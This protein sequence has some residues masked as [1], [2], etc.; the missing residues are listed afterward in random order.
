[1]RSLAQLTG[2]DLADV[3]TAVSANGERAFG[4]WQ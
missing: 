4:P 2:R 3:C 1:M